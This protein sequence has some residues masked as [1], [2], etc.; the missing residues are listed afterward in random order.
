MTANKHN[1]FL[2][3]R[4]VEI[5]RQL[6]YKNC[7]NSKKGG[8]NVEINGKTRK[9]VKENNNNFPPKT[10]FVKRN[11]CKKWLDNYCYFTNLRQTEIF[12]IDLNFG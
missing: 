2:I 8:K 6:F 9:M 3:K 5:F 10:I 11:S 4:L 1:I 12:A 7:Q